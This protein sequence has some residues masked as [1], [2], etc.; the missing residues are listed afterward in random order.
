MDRYFNVMI[1]L[2][3]VI[4]GVGIEVILSRLYFKKE[5]EG[6]KKHQVVHFKLSRYLFLISVPILGV[7]YMASTVSVSILKYFLVFAFLGT[8]LEYCIGYAY[9][10]IVGQRL[11][12][13]NKFSIKGHTSLLSIPL[14]GLCGSLIYLLAQTIS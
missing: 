9:L 4:L 1:F 5:G 13:Y 2:G 11:W 3:I 7:L 10:A 6:K 8:F 14:W 12:T